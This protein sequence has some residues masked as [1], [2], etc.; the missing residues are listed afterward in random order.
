[1]SELR[2]L[3]L[4]NAVENGTVL[5]A[6]LNTY[7]TDAGR[8]AEFTVLFSQRGQAK[9]IANGQTTMT[10]IVNSIIATDA[11]FLQATSSNDTIVAAVVESAL[12]MSTVSNISSVLETVSD[13]P[14]SWGYFSGSIYYE[15]HIKNIIAHL[16]GVDPSLYGS[17]SLLILDPVSMGDISVSERG[18]R[19]LVN[20][21]PSATIMAGDSVAM[22]LV[23]ADTTAITLVAKQT[24]IMPAIA[25]NVEAMDEIVSRGV[26]TG[27][28]ASN[29]GAIQAISV[30]PTGWAN[31]L[32]SPFFATNLKNII[33][34]IASLDPS[35]FVDVNAII[36]NSTALTAV[37]NNSQASQ[38]LSTSSAAVS[39]LASS[40]NLSIILGSV[41]AM[42]HFGTE[43]GIQA[44]LNVP[45]A[46]PTVFSSSIAKGV[47]MGSTSIVDSIAANST[48]L[49][50]LSGLT[51][52]S[53]PASLRTSTTSAD[54]P[55]DGIPNKVLVL[56]MRANN[57][58][59]IAVAY[60]FDGS[61]VAG[62]N[63]ST[64]SISLKGTVTETTCTAYTDPTWTVAGIGATVAVLPEWTWVDM[65]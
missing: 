56:G 23:A 10:A 45:A 49:A 11:A 58:G 62:S 37:A 15:S 6:E 54:D 57:I 14:T 17:V 39:T 16:S 53:V 55:F 1:M 4:L 33:C 50:Y 19:A 7:L 52:K 3:R 61:L 35:L 64:G 2:P 44:F 40:P 63:P 20:S 51:V 43:A 8:L 28:M 9:R 60:D 5:G 18:M 65:T 32:T 22:A 42:A 13:N 48:T 25:N 47:I 34:N 41:V 59:A 46:V 36:A 30:N 26:A 31:Y 29:A 38:A 27:V 24:S 21:L 12:A